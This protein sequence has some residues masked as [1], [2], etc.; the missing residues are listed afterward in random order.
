MASFA[1]IK[2]FSANTTVLKA[3]EKIPNLILIK[4]GIVQLVKP[5]PKP[6][7]MTVKRSND[8]TNGLVINEEFTEIPGLL[9]LQKTWNT[10]LDDETKRQY[11][12]NNEYVDFTVGI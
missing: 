3:N 2:S 10:Y 9:I 6:G 11:A 12:G 5:I 1:I 8:R 4:S 7:L